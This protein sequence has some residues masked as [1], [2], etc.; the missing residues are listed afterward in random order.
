MK[1]CRKCGDTKPAEMFPSRARRHSRDGLGSYCRECQR[2]L[3]REKTRRWRAKN[4]EAARKKATEASRRLRARDPE[5]FRRWYVE[6][7]DKERERSKL[8]MRQIRAANPEGERATQ[9]RYRA[10]NIEVVRMREREKTYA[11]RA[12]QPCSPELVQLMAELVTQPCAYC[13][14]TETITIDHIMPLS[15]GGKHEA[16][17]LAP[18][19]LPCNSSKCNRLLSEWDGR[20]STPCPA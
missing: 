17:N 13:G 19:C 4:P 18:A 15:R 1:Q 8:V 20:F 12:K 10:K 3:N 14:A 5:Y 2:V 16:E 9:R 6:N 11:R 7:A